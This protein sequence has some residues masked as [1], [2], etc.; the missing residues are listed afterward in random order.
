MTVEKK[1]LFLGSIPFFCLFILLY[2]TNLFK[3]VYEHKIIDLEVK[4]GKV[5]IPA[6]TLSEP[7]LFSL[8]GD[9][10]YTPN[11]FY[12]L[13]NSPEESYAKVPGDIS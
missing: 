11:R 10:Y 5:S 13:K 12:S 9:F 8:S 2:L 6:K 4:N 3:L 7:S 1:R